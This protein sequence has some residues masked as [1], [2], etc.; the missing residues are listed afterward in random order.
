MKIHFYIANVCT[1]TEVLDPD[2]YYDCMANH[3]QKLEDVWRAYIQA[4]VTE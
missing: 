2:C 3:S 1:I 4:W